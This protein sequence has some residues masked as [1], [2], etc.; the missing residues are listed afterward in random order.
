LMGEEDAVIGD[1]S[2]LEAKDGVAGRGQGA[3][4]GWGGFVD[5]WAHRCVFR[6]CRR[7]GA[8]GKDARRAG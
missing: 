4:L 5:L 1:F 3:R 6:R 2:A 8:T 7:K